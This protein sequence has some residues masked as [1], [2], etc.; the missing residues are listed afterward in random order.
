MLQRDS[1]IHEVKWKVQGKQWWY[2]NGLVLA[3]QRRKNAPFPK[4]GNNSLPPHLQANIE[5]VMSIQEYGK[6]HLDDLYWKMMMEY[7]HDTLITELVNKEETE[8]V[9]FLK[10]Y[11]ITIFW[12]YSS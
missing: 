2:I 10:W 9:G 7:I 8:K 4:I 11:N 6:Y 5:A 1:K 3:I 12:Q